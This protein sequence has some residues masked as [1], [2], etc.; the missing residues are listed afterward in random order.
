MVYYSFLSPL[1][2]FEVQKSLKVFWRVFALCFSPMFTE[3]FYVF[4]F[5]VACIHRCPITYECSDVVVLQ[6]DNIVFLSAWFPFSLGL[7]LYFF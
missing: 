3:F 6:L 7:L 5:L 1:Y 2:G 4:G